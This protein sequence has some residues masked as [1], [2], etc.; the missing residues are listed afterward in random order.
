METDMGMGMP[1]DMPMQM[2]QGPPPGQPP[3]PAGPAP[4]AT[5]TGLPPID[6]MQQDKNLVPHL[7][8][9]ELT[10][11]A[12]ICCRD[13]DSDV[14]SRRPRMKRLAEYQGIYA[15]VM[16]AKNFPWTDAANVNLPT[17]TYP[18]LQVQGRLYD[19]IWPANGKI[20]YSS[21]TNS[22][23]VH[24]ANVT[25]MFGNAYIR[26][27]MPEMAQGLD[28]TLHQC[29]GYGSAFRRTYWNEYEE[30]AASDWIP[31]A[32]FVVMDTQRS[33]DPSMR[34]VPRYTLVQRLNRFDLEA[35]GERGI[36]LNV[37]KI[38]WGDPDK[39]VETAFEAKLKQIDGITES[40]DASFDDKP[41]MVIEQHR[42]WK[43]PD[44]SGLHIDLDGKAHAVIITVDYQSKQVLR[45]V[46]RE[47]N[48]PADHSRYQ[49]QAQEFEGFTQA[50][51]AFEAAL[52]GPPALMMGPTGPM[53]APAPMP[54]PM[55]K[56]MKTDEDGAS[57]PP[58]AQRKR[59]IC[60]F[61][62]YRAFPS[63]GFYG[64][65]LGDFLIGLVKAINTLANQHIDGLTLRN[66]KGGFISKTM[67]GQRGQIAISPGK[68]V[69]VDAPMGAL[70]DGIAWLE[71]PQNDPTTMP[72]ISMLMEA[73][74]KLVASSDLMSGQTSGANRTAKETQIL[75]E[76]MMM[77]ITVLARRM[78][79]AQRHEIDKLWRIWGVFLP[80]EE[81][82]NV[83]GE[84]GS[85]QELKVGRA[86][87]IPDAHVIPA[88]DPRT[89]TQ[90]I[91][92]ATAVFTV[93]TT[94]PYLMQS[95]NRD[96]IMRA[97]TE[98]ML[99]AHGAE[100]LLKMMPPPQGPP[101]PPQPKQAWEEDADALQSKPHPVLPGDDDQGHLFG[102]GGH[103]AFQGSPAHKSMS[104]EQKAGHE[105]HVRDHH[106]AMIVKTA[107]RSGMSRPPQG[108]PPQMPPMGGPQ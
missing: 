61:T 64:L 20:F 33:Q 54:P 97:V 57:L 108:A 14:E 18:W 3:M 12:D 70:K 22:G 89:K 4:F 82:V 29:V 40:D 19:M 44:Q 46:V 91:E 15:S 23:D 6:E 8:E 34:D 67:K 30:R 60:F 63:E 68:F 55:P 84:D 88:A 81:I 28:D 27:K 13:Y 41:R 2:P 69:E 24:R 72:M 99:R 51:D 92:D 32:D 94:N 37:D 39:P 52:S 16:K 10:N 87:F 103:I 95:P 9:K 7:T 42:T 17:L 5:T 101:P 43:L 45:I 79:E 77:Q 93:V 98:D 56:W 48:D 21:P 58:R 86:M 73:A 107:Q 75:A 85:P 35:W 65:G 50:R 25:E 100:K 59:E 47:E 1:P 62:H 71:P 49:R 38:Q 90:R 104:K 36:Y 66:A 102:P 74:D 105:Q 106:A 96:T 53:Q 11:I 83:V 80:D 31:I 78:K 76:Q 26:Q